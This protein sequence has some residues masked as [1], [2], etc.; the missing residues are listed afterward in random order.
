MKKFKNQKLTNEQLRSLKGGTCY[1]LY[2]EAGDGMTC[3]VPVNGFPV[4]GTIQNG[5]CCV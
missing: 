5:Q 4:F 1:R 2:F 3:A